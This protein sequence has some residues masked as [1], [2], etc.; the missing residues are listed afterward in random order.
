TGTAPGHAGALAGSET[1][2]SETAADADVPHRAVLVTAL[3]AAAHVGV[4]DV[5]LVEEVASG[6][7]Q[8]EVLV[9]LPVDADVPH[10]ACGAVQHAVV[11][12]GGSVA[13]AADAVLGLVVAVDLDIQP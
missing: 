9:E 5:R 4:D 8:V 2:A 7:L 1:V 6:Q 10:L 11:G 3:H 12:G 13:E